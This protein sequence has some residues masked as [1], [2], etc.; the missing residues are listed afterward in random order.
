QFGGHRHD[1][2][3]AW[4]GAPVRRQNLWEQGVKRHV[5]A[6][7]KVLRR[8]TRPALVAALVLGAAV[9]RTH[10]APADTGHGAVTATR[11]AKFNFTASV[12]TLTFGTGLDPAG[13]ACS[14]CSNVTSYVDPADSG[15]YYVN[16]S[17]A[18]AFA[19]V[20][21]IK[22]NKAYTGK[23]AATA[24]GGTSGQTLASLKWA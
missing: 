9:A 6:F 16:N 12:T 14:G 1:L 22:S 18:S 17:N 24:N 19:V 11:S 8:A 21:T 20:V 3:S 5:M 13:S 15:A 2:V 10:G 7:S 4:I 23:V